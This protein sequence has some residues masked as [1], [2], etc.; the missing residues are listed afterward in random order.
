MDLD[1]IN[2][3]E[4][5]EIIK[6]YE[7]LYLSS[8]SFRILLGLLKT[9]IELNEDVETLNNSIKEL[10]DYFIKYGKLPNLQN[11]LKKIFK[12]IN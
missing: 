6:N 12:K 8:F 3:E 5:A 10:K 1:S 9:R 11:D 4:W 2:N 7:K